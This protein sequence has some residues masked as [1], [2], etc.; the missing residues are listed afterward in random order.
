MSL[1]TWRS[2]LSLVSAKAT[3][4]D[5]VASANPAM[6]VSTRFVIGP[7]VASGIARQVPMA[8]FA[9]CSKTPEFCT[10]S[11]TMS[12]GVDARAS[13]ARECEA[14]AVGDRGFD[15]PDGRHL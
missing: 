15:D 8:G 4:V 10:A 1:N 12:S 9:K 7:P 3:V 2:F 5:N 13:V 6:N 14:E 11:R